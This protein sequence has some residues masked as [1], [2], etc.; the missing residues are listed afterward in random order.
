MLTVAS[1]LPEDR[2]RALA[3]G[4]E[5]PARAVGCVLVVDISG[6]TPL[7]EAL[8]RA[9]GERDGA[10]A[11]TRHL[12]RIYTELTAALHAYGGSIV[13]FSGDGM[14][15]WFDAAEDTPAGTATRALAAAA[16]VQARMHT[17]AAVPITA[18]LTI[19]LAVKTALAAGEV[20]RMVVGDPARQRI[21]VMAGP[22]VDAAAQG[23]QLAARGQIVV[24]ASTLALVR[25]GLQAVTP[26]DA[27][28]E[29]FFAVEPVAGFP[30]AVA[31]RAPEPDPV[32]ADEDAAP[33]LLPPVRA[34]L[35]HAGGRFLGEIRP[36][37]ALFVRFG[38][39][40]FHTDPAA[41]SKLDAYVRWV[42]EVLAR[43][44]GAL[45]QL[46][47]GDKGSYLYAAFGAPVAH[48]DE[49]GRAVGTARRLLAPP[50]SLPY[51][52]RPQI[53]MAHGRMR[54]G[55][56]GSATRA[57][58]GVQGAA[59]NLAARLMM[60]A[61]PGEIILDAATADFL[62]DRAALTPFPP[63]VL[64]GHDAPTAL[65][66]LDAE[67]TQAPV[68][69][70]TSTTMPL[71]GRDDA[72]HT[73]DRVLA[74]QR[75]G[76]RGALVTVTGDAGMGKSRLLAAW[77]TMAQGAA[78]VATGS[79][80]STEQR[81]AYF[82][83]RPVV[84]MLLGLDTLPHAD[85][86]VQIA[87][88]TTAVA[89]V[90]AAWAVRVPLLADLLGLPVVDNEVT[91]SLDARQR[92]EAL[93]DLV[94]GLLGE[95]ALR[96]PV[97]IV[98]DDAQWLD[99]GSAAL[100]G[101]LAVVTLGASVLLVV[102]QRTG[103]AA[104]RLLPTAVAD[105]VMVLDIKIG[106]LDQ[107]Q[108]SA[109]L[110]AWL[111]RPPDELT[112]ALVW[113]RSQGNP[114]MVEA[115][116]DALQHAGHLVRTDEDVWTLTP[117]I[118]ERLRRSGALVTT[119]TGDALRA[120]Q[121][122]FG[123]NLPSS[124]HG[125]VLTQID[126]LP[127]RTKLT[128]KTASVL[129]REFPRALLAA[130]HPMDDGGEGLAHDLRVLTER[131]I[132]EGESSAAAGF[133][134][135]HNITQEVVYR[136]LLD[137]QRREL[138]G[139]AARAL[140][141]HDP[142]A[143][144]QLAHHFYHADLSD[145]AIQTRS[146]HYLD[147]AAAL[148][149]RDYANETALHQVERALAL[150]PHWARYKQQAELLHI[151]GRRDDEAAAL[152]R[153]ADC[154]D[155]PAVDVAL[156]EGDYFEAVSRYDEAT[157]A[158]LR[159]RRAAVASGVRAA[160]AR[161]L[162]RLGMIAW[163]QGSYSAAAEHYAEALELLSRNA[164]LVAE[165]ADVRYGLG[166]VHRQQGHY[167]AAQA[168]FARCLDL[169]RGQ[170][171]RPAE[172]KTL[173]ALGHVAHHRQDLEAAMAAYESAL[174]IYRETGDRAGVASSELSIGQGLSARGA[175]AE[176]VRHLATAL[177]LHRRLGDSWWR[178]ID[179]NELGVVYMLVGQFAQAETH[180]DA[181][182]RLSRDLEDDSGMAY[183][184]CNL[185][186]I[187]RARQ[188][189]A[190]A[191]QYLTDGCALAE[192]QGDQVLRANCLLELALVSL[193]QNDCRQAIER[194]DASFEAYAALNL[195]EQNIT[196]LSTLACAHQRL[197]ANDA[198]AA[199]ADAALALL[200]ETDGAG[201]AYP[202][203]EYVVLADLFATWSLHDR[204]DRLR[205]RAHAIMA[206][207]AGAITDPAMRSS[208]LSALPFHRDLVIEFGEP[209]P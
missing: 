127:E 143:V 93:H 15:C 158:M 139:R 180:F 27:G 179:H 68:P 188:A 40:D 53:G 25:A 37:V 137:E 150:E 140:E 57:S 9:L 195:P 200:R 125:L 66:R 52:P 189:H 112:A 89:A 83:L 5:L 80:R 74:D 38:D 79:A 21:D 152:A 20:R 167:D 31:R 146:L 8:V 33:W 73:L 71:L 142:D 206:R 86:D 175:Y 159:A 98:L 4:H 99:E 156:A 163:R 92:R 157:D 84:R 181:A 6:F 165:E 191:L 60:Q 34:Q 65:F 115:L 202:Q 59:V 16:E 113:Q 176:A 172:A 67:L 41:P 171:N 17:L 102:A 47:T 122:D 90:N 177:D 2:R 100:L 162:A 164:M 51:R 10:D 87:H 174:P 107:V 121:G 82:A 144:A 131:G 103:G 153:L 170:G 130:A 145:A 154:A 135:R 173:I 63:V 18:T 169:Y 166:L 111:G 128:L 58:Y 160:E 123:L 22:A 48:D 124:L 116:A 204:A 184:Y 168:E 119:R 203:R 69:P 108:V 1:F 42:Q 35:A 114:L 96:R 129:G 56:Y 94:A 106:G 76:A 55:P 72:L 49:I 208:F 197:G 109:L 77:S 182:L 186:Q 185:G 78:T 110:A 11:A 14:L 193:E 155:A 24:S 201:A 196:N 141:A 97:V 151:L 54:V 105:D 133:A 7:T 45:I 64:K 148:A 194:A 36:A 75:T 30:V 29:Q 19:T 88:L 26:V 149:Q 12:N 28:P 147:R 126:A 178:S 199:Y 91:A 205:R 39:L 81:T 190:Q 198:A 62:T 50:A 32:L 44:D 61:Q 132:L 209:M 70:R 183:V 85:A 13:G 101:E 138:H 118:Q 120:V 207:Q 134:F 104:R 3:T 43:Y 23:E 136:T 95:R 161:A 117:D 187:A 46:T 192:A